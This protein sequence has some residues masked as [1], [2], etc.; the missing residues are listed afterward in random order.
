M[1]EKQLR[2]GVITQ[3]RMG[4]SRLFGKIFLPVGSQTLLQTH[5]HRL[6]QADLPVYVATTTRPLDEQI[7]HF[8]MAH[9]LDFFRGDEDDVLSRYYAT[10]LQ[11]QLDVIVRVTSD[12]PL[13]DGALIQQGLQQFLAA[14][15]E[16][17]YLSNGLLRTFPRGFDFE[18]FTFSLLAEAF[19]NASLPHEREHVTPYM[20]LRANANTLILPFTQSVDKSAY[21][22]TLDVK[23]DYALIYAL[24][25]NH[26]ADRLS[27]SEI[28][29]ILDAHPELVL[30]NSHVEQKKLQS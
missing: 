3:A 10:A 22:I 8:C 9:Q 2:V 25:Q 30:I 24:I 19:H 21:R 20:Y 12:C 27:H 26:Q 16:N 1:N 4:S 29:Q 11:Y 23:E 7:A 6:Q 15:A 17:K 18:I 14:P 28:T 5:I 13:I